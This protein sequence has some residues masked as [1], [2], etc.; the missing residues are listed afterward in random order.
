MQIVSGHGIILDTAPQ[1]R[2]GAL[3]AAH[4]FLTGRGI[5]SLEADEALARARIERAF[6]SDTRGFVHDCTKH[7]DT[8]GPCFTDAR[9]VWMVNGLPPNITG[10]EPPRPVCLSRADPVRKE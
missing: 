2:A 10:G 8:P 6:Y 4:Q 5:D 7:E 3:E 9:E 1:R